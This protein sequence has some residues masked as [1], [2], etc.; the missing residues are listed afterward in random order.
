MKISDVI[1]ELQK[2]QNQYGDL[3]CWVHA[4]DCHETAEYVRPFFAYA[5]WPHDAT[6]EKNP[7]A[8]EI[9]Y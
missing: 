5:N 2:L 1:Q 8:V 3:D 9:T 6:L 7:C 4:A